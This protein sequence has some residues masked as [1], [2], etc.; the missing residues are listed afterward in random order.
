MEINY[1]TINRLERRIDAIEALLDHIVRQENDPKPTK[2][3]VK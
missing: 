1:E 2:R 3:R